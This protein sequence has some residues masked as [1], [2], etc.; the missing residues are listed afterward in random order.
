MS[1]ASTS[2]ALLNSINSEK[3]ARGTVAYQRKAGWRSPSCEIVATRNNW[4]SQ[5]GRG[6]IRVLTRAVEMEI[7]A[8][9]GGQKENADGNDA[10]E[11]G[12]S[13]AVSSLPRHRI[14]VW[15]ADMAAITRTHYHLDRTIDDPV[16]HP[17][18]RA[19][20]RIDDSGDVEGRDVVFTNYEGAVAEA[21]QPNETAPRQG[22]GLAPPGTL[23]ALKALGFNLLSLA[24]NHSWDLKVPGIQNTI[25]EVGRLNLAHAGTG[26]TLEEA[27]A[28]GYLHTPKGTV[29]LV[30]MASGLVPQGVGHRYPAG[31]ERAPCGSR[32]QAERGG[33]ETILQ[34]I[35]DAS[36][37][38]DLVIVYQH[39][40]VF[41]KPFRDDIRRRVTRSVSAA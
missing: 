9:R 33:R 17:C 5:K 11:M 40:H 19:F 18:H 36:K 35:A 26:N 34:S 30:A 2:G 8:Q 6:C 16:R 32:E 15:R 25:Q 4:F 31:R 27:A 21:G 20:G 41:D 7:P 13:S 39:N 29:A 22:G 1:V 23:G 12:P 37:R 28:P 3:S 10:I 38:A 24:N 14:H